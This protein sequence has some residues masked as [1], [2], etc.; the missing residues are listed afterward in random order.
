MGSVVDTGLHVNG[1]A[2]PGVT[3]ASAISTIPRAMIN[4]AAIALAETAI[5]LV[6]GG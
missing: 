3:N 6:L 2:G 4:A 5:D 1:V